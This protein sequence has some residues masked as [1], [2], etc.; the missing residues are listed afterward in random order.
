LNGLESAGLAW[1]LPQGLS[2]GDLEA[3]LAR[4]ARLHQLDAIF[5]I[6]GASDRDKPLVLKGCGL[7][8]CL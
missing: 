2:D 1:P 5:T 3:P 8:K 7:R 6:F 4:L